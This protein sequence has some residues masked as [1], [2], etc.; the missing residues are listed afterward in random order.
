VNHRNA[1]T[2]FTLVELLVVIGIIAVLAGLLIVGVGA[3]TRKAQLANTRF[4]MTSMVQAMAR[5]KADHG[6]YPPVLG[7][8]GSLSAGAFGSWTSSTTRSA[9]PTTAGQM[10]FPSGQVGWMR[11]LLISP[12]QTAVPGGTSKV[13][14]WTSAESKALQRWHSITS[15]AEY[16]L[17][18]GDRSADGYGICGTLPEIPPPALKPGQREVPRDGLRSPGLDGVWGAAL[19]PRMASDL[20]GTTGGTAPYTGSSLF[21]GRNVGTFG[22]RNLA[23]PARSKVDAVA[24]DL[25]NDDAACPLRFQPNLQGKVFGP[26]L[27]LKDPGTLGGIRGIRADGEWDVVRST[28]GDPNFDLYPK[29]IVDYWGSPIRYYRKGYMNFSPSAPDTTQDGTAFDLGDF[30]ALRPTRADEADFVPKSEAARECLDDENPDLQM[31]GEFQG[32]D[33]SA[34]RRLRAADVALLSAGPDRRVDLT[35]RLGFSGPNRTRDVNEDNI[36][37]TG[38]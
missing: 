35:R 24:N 16:L 7:D 34:T 21:A 30:F 22:A 14:Q 11:D 15:P 17:G 10:L 28:E 32:R 12:S 37:E 19:T 27:E 20:A 4:L 5:F 25:G 33:R 9:G 23:V 6:Y 31:D 13:S 38:P 1:R 2:A 36:V 29:C 8:P 18:W 3:A 26:Y